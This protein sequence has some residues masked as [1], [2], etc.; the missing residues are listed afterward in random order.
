MNRFSN[1]PKHPF[2]LFIKPSI[3]ILLL[4]IGH[5]FIAAQESNSLLYAH[6]TVKSN[7]TTDWN[8]LIGGEKMYYIDFD[9]LQVKVEMIQLKS[10]NGEVVFEDNVKELS[11][12][13]FY[14]LNLKQLKDGEY[15]L[16]LLTR[17]KTLRKVLELK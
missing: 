16:D 12:R 14:A 3:T 9:E 11:K 15:Y 2:I 17:N 6:A 5:Y 4:L 10:L 8:F 7:P 1:A 13:T